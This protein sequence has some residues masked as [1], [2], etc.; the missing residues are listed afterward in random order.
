VFNIVLPHPCDA[1]LTAP[2]TPFVVFFFVAYPHERQ[3]SRRDGCSEGG[4]A[5]PG[6]HDAEHCGSTPIQATR[7]MCKR[8]QGPA[9]PGGEVGPRG[10]ACTGVH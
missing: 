5:V 7:P 9:V 8:S 4:I 1:A 10:A 2:V 3:N 6:Q